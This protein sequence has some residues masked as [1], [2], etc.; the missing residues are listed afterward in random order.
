MTREEHLIWCK[1]RAISEYDYYKDQ[2]DKQRNGLISM[3]SDM[4][5]HPETKSEVVAS[6][7]L[8]NMIKPMSRQE[9]V[10]FINGFN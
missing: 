7:C 2:S 3:M 6:L 9:F 8:L 5:K 1:R 10:D 4:N